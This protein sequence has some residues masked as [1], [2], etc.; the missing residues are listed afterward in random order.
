MS[1][2]IKL[3][4]IENT[5]LGLQQVKKDFR[6]SKEMIEHIDVVQEELDEELECWRELIYEEN[7][8]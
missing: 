6:L 7:G 3:Q 1:L 2:T 8:N 5:I 4:N